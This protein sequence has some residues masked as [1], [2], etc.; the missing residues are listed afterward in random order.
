[1]Q[2]WQTLNG[3]SQWAFQMDGVITRTSTTGGHM[4]VIQ[5]ANDFEMFSGNSAGAIQGNG[6]QCRNAG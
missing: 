6:Y 3:A 5:N 2:T 4:I 1:M